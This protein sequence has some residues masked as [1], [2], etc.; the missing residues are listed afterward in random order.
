MITPQRLLSLSLRVGALALLS[1]A[2]LGS[3]TAQPRIQIVGGD[4]VNFGR[5]ATDSLR[6]EIVIKNVG[7]QTLKI[8]EIKPGCG[9]TTAQPLTK[10]ELAPNEIAKV[11]IAINVKGHQ[12]IQMKNVYVMSNDPDPSR[13]TVTINYKADV[14]QD[15][16]ASAGIFSMVS[17]AQVGGEYPSTLTLT[18]TSDQ[19]ITIQPP[20]A[21][22]PSEHL[23]VNFDMKEP[24]TL[25]PGEQLEL[26]AHVKPDRPGMYTTEVDVKTSGAV[27]PTMSFRLITHSVPAEAATPEGTAKQ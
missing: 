27:T 14:I 10:K 13:D 12:G 23:T 9:C 22:T 26:V 17:N 20:T 24:K 15:V 19:P 2:G 4:S 1:F 6:H 18:N 21:T 5:I 7:N 8:T 3:A 11:G 16:T 25:K